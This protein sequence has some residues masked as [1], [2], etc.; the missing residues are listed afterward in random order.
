MFP[1]CIAVVSI[2]PFPTILAF[3]FNIVALQYNLSCVKCLAVLM[4]FCV[5]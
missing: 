4:C 5:M 3:D 2:L 1:M